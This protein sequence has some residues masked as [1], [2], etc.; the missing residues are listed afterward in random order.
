MS[1]LNQSE[2]NLNRYLLKEVSAG[3]GSVAGHTGRKGVEVDDTLAGPFHPDFMDLKDTLENQFKDR[4]EAR[5]NLS[6]SDVEYGGESPLGGY[7]DIHTDAA[8]ETY[9]ILYAD[10][11]EKEKFNKE[12]T[13]VLDIKFRMT[14]AGMAMF[15]DE[16]GEAPRV[17]DIVYDDNSALYNRVKDIVYD[18]EPTYAGENFINKSETNWKIIR[19]I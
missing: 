6:L 9:D 14:D 4:K 12:V 16:P 18:D 7:N 13:P 15:Y 8:I 2:N 11:E 5:K 17:R 1:F 10:S 3:G 19:E